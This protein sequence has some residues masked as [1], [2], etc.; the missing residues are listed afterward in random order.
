MTEQEAMNKIQALVLGR[1]KYLG[2]AYSG[3]C[4]KCQNIDARY[5]TS[6]VVNGSTECEEC[7]INRKYSELAPQITEEDSSEIKDQRAQ[8]VRDYFKLRKKIWYQKN[9]ESTANVNEPPLP[10]ESKASAESTDEFLND[11]K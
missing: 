2:I 9:E 8:T 6:S 7:F 3:Y 5:L 10:E 11:L 1:R 4:S